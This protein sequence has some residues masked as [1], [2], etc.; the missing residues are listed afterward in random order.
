[1]QPVTVANAG[2]NQT[3]CNVTSTTMAANAP[4]SGTG[5]WTQVSGPTT[6]SFTN[7]NNPFTTV[8][9]L[10]PGTY[11]FQWTITNNPCT[12]SQS[13]VQVHIDP[14]TV[15]GTLASP[16]T[17]CAVSNTGTLT[18]SGYTSTIL[19]WQSSV[20]NGTTWTNITNTTANYTY[21]NLTATTL[22]RAQVQSGSCAAQYSN[23]VAIT[24][25]QAVTPSNAG[26]NQA[27]CN[28]T[29]TTMAATAATS[30][31]GTWTMVSGP[32]AASFTDSH[33]PLLL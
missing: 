17:V 13:T 28:V 18:L 20:D 5:T 4:L 16:A 9:N 7:A 15:P 29:S 6:A 12:A 2:S 21:N 30:G 33:N 8:N 22:F 23:N 19:N 1:M 11:Q 27:L 26:P 25:A 10:I 24:V 14:A 32:S 3:L 31:T